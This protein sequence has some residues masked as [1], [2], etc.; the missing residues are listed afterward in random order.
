[1]C[2]AGLERLPWFNHDKRSRHKKKCR[3]GLTRRAPTATAATV[4]EK[5]TGG[6][7]PKPRA[8]D[9]GCARLRIEVGYA[10]T[11]HALDPTSVGIKR[12]R[13]RHD[14]GTDSVSN[15]L[16]QSQCSGIVRAACAGGG[17]VL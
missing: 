16:Q 14:D 11:I 4:V 8:N 1:M 13:R 17:A 15:I 5:N 2:A 6:V 10:G 9:K 7:S 12:K 3:R